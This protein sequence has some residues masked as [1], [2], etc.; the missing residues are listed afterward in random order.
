MIKIKAVQENPKVGDIKG[1]TLLIENHLNLAKKEGIDLLVFSEMFLS[2]YPPEDLVM[3]DDF[4]NEIKKSI[5]QIIPQTD[6]ISLIF[7]APVKKNE[8][9]FNACLL[10]TSPSPRDS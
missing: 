5:E 9:L 10:Y 7:G 1:N 3:R 2:G 8:L 6:G 4:L